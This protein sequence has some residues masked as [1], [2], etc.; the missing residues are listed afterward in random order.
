MGSTLA[1]V[2]VSNAE[3]LDLR[4]ELDLLGNSG[5]TYTIVNSVRIQKVVH[6][7]FSCVWLRWCGQANLNRNTRVSV[8]LRA[9]N[10]P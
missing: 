10:I 9:L 5:A 2:E 6:A 1:K 7:L 4:A 8:S 3:R